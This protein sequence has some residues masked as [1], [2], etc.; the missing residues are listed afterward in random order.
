[1]SSLIEARLNEL[2][3]SLPTAPEAVGYYVPATRIGNLVVTSGQ[4][5]MSGKEL[6][7]SGKI[8][9]TNVESHGTSAA[10]I[11]ALNALAQIKALIGNL[12]KI[13]R[14]VRVEGYVASAPG[15]TNQAQVVN[16]ASRLLVDL[17]GEAGKHTRIAVGA[18]ELPLDASVELVIWAEVAD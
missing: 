10:Q 11:C 7:F 1:M 9:G 14:I 15:F 3:L 17:F 5:P 8:G 4:L 6:L 13:Q 2:E 18:A 16:G 12:D